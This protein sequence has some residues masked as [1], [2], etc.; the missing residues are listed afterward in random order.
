MTRAKRKC[1][2]KHCRKLFTPD[3]RN[4]HKQMYCGEPACRKASKTASQAKWLAKEGNED[5]FRGPDNVRR[6]QEWRK[7]NPGYWRRKGNKGRDALQDHSTNKNTQ[8]QSVTQQLPRNVLQDLLNEQLPVFVGLI[9]N[10]TGSALQDDIVTTTRRLQQLGADI[11][12]L[13]SPNLQ[14]GNYDRQT[15]YSSPPDP[16][17]S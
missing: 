10:F 4:A 8:K 1:R 12:N 2:C 17:G 9:A 15:A 13:Q 7:A 6:V 5:Y 14:G 11:L 16:P 3:P